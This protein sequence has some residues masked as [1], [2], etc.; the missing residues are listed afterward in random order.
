MLGPRRGPGSF[1]TGDA[2]NAAAL[3]E[4]AAPFPGAAGPLPSVPWSRIRAMKPERKPSR[5]CWWLVLSARRC[6]T[7]FLKPCLTLFLHVVTGFL[8]CP[9][10]F[11][12]GLRQI[13]WGSPDSE[14]YK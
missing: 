13:F 2:G 1:P 14:Y 12:A 10:I 8:P 11:I 7:Q 9:P 6:L 5:T 4:G 3:P